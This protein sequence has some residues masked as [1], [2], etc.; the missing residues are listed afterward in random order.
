MAKRALIVWGGWDGHEPEAVAGVFRELLVE[1]G[2]EVATETSL[3]A[4]KDGE[5]LAAQD[6]VV[7]VWTMGTITQEQ[8]APL[9]KAVTRGVGLAG[10]HGGMCDSFREATDYQFMTGG[11]WVAHPGNDGVTYEVRIT[12]DH[13]ITEGRRNFEV[14][15]EQY[16]LHVD[17]SNTVLA[18]TRF[19][20][21]D[22]PHAPNGPFDMPVVWVRL[23][24][25][26][27]VFYTSLGHTASALR[28]PESREI[29]R[30]GL[31][32]AARAEPKG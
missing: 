3:D 24:G 28:H 22:G 26:G 20:I 8:L 13:W 7:P 12:G 16:Y 18:V 23:H 21:A 4:Y 17:P 27:R 10:C 9:V 15:S 1:E 19:P 30:R 14:T 31:L 25:Q 6:V 11:Q 32:W 5:R 29:C 2:F